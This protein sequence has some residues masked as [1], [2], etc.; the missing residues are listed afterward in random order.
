MPKPKKKVIQ[1]IEGW[2]CVCPNIGTSPQFWIGDK[3]KY[4]MHC[5]K[6]RKATLIIEE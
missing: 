4:G 6:A 3:Y 1:G 2:A 5:D